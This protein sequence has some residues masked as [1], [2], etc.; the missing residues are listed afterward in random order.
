LNPDD[1]GWGFSGLL[2]PGCKNRKKHG[3]MMRLMIK[4][5]NLQKECINMQSM[6]NKNERLMAIRK[7]IG[8]EDISSQDELLKLLEDEGFNMTQA[9]LSRDLKYLRIA[10]M[11]DNENGYVYILP[12][13]ENQAAE[14]DYS[15]IPTSGFVSID[16]AQ[17]MAIMRTLPGHASSIGY[18]LDNMNAYEIAGTIAGDDT[19][20]IIPRDGVTKGDLANLLKTRIPV[21]RQDS[22]VLISPQVSQ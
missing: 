22:P 18:A 17:G 11:P 14:A 4:C 7:L 16:Y 13:K 10:K 8:D 21:I 2:D 15:G 3:K 12:E 20:L 6:K 9:T 1:T 19:I 5:I